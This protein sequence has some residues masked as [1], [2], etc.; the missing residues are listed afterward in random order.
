MF[1]A[2]GKS[3]GA[4]RQRATAKGPAHAREAAGPEAAERAR[5][6]RERKGPAHG[7]A[8]AIAIPAGAALRMLRRPARLH[9]ASAGS[10]GP[11]IEPRCRAARASPPGRRSLSVPPPRTPGLP[12]KIQSWELPACG[13]FVLSALR[14]L[15]IHFRS[16]Y[17]PSTMCQADKFP[18]LLELTF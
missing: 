4:A 15:I 13:A 7:D 16:M 5:L 10:G 14:M 17:C 9:R 1:P 12:A 11:A 2:R 6:G 8:A 18:A 3:R